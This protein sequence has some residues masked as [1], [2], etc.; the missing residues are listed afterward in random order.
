MDNYLKFI[1]VFISSVVL[2]FLLSK[3]VIALAHRF[4]ILDY[5][6]SARKIHSRP[7]PLLGGLAVYF[8]L[9]VMTLILWQKGYLFDP[10]IEPS[11]VA[12]FMLS[13]LI[14]MLNGYL[15]DKYDIKPYVSIWGPILASLAVIIGGLKIAYI[16][17]PGGGV[18]YLDRFFDSWPG[19]G[20]LIIFILTFLWLLGITY[21]TKLLD[22]IDGLA[23][24]I[25]F[26][27]SLVIFVVSLSWDVVGSTT[28]LLAISLAGALLGFL[29]VNWHPAKIFLGEGGSTFI[30]FSLGVLAIISGS[31]IVTALLVMGLPLLDI[32][33]VIVRRLKQKK[34]WYQGDNEHLHFRLL[35]AGFSQRQVVGFFASVSLVF[36]LVSIFFTTKT[37][38]GALLILLA[39]MFFLSTW[40]NY[41]LKKMESN[42]TYD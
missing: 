24:S 11:N 12:W 9:L 15:D 22:G 30:G 26:I 5:P 18:L 32:F 3:I 29:F 1:V 13:G 34:A 10:R 35:R 28:S 14:L 27:S 16:T 38:I 33:W 23:T 2:C 39:V 17:N 40:L 8:T 25:G 6:K 19:G 42:Q 7:T 36:G 41:K 4:G 20:E 31:K 21:T 37:K